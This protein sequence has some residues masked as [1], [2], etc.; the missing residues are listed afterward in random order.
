MYLFRKI[1]NKLN[2]LSKLNDLFNRKERLEFLGVITASFLM[3]VFQAIGV[4]SI[5]PFINMVM[6][7]AVISENQW[8]NYFFNVFGFESERQFI[9]FSGF[10]VLCLLVLGNSISAFA[11][12]LKIHFVWKKNH[13]LS[14][15]LLEK[16]LS[17]PYAFFLNQNTAELGKN[18]LAEVQQLTS[19][20]LMPLT[21][22]ITD[23]IVVV[24]IFA[25][26]VYVNPLMTAAAAVILVLLYF[27]I[28]FYFSRQLKEGGEKR[29][30]QNM[31]R[32]KSANEALGGIKDIKMLG[33]ESYFLRKFFNS[34]EIFSNVQS[35]YQTV[36]QVPRY[37]M[38]IVAFGGIVGLVI[39][40]TGT[41]KPMQEAIPLISFFAFAGYRLMPALQEVFNSLTVIRFNKAVLDKIHNDMTDKSGSL[42][43]EAIEQKNVRSL[44]FQKEIRL[45]NVRFTYPNNNKEALK[46]VSLSIRKNSSAAIIGATGS[47]KTTL[48]DIVL[49]LFLPD[50]GK[51]AVDGIEITKNNVRNWQA[52]LGYVPQFIYL[53]DDTIAR[54]IALG[55]P[56]QNINMDQVK[57]AAEMA[58]IHEFIDEELSEGY[59]TIIGERGI[60]LSGGQRQRIGIAR[61]LYHDP[62]VLI[63]DEATS[64]LDN[65]TEKE[66]LKAIDSVAK[67]KTM[68]VIA[69]RLTTVKNCDKVYLINKGEI[70]KEGTYEE[71][72]NKKDE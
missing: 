15:A 10:V 16:Y 66:V 41:G 58:N 65:E 72:V 70:V 3:A 69:H 48:A 32:Y 18:I 37:I 20:F 8:L 61:A 27:S 34:S 68:V 30:E 71:I 64:S 5:L 22:I 67:L 7:P 40:L 28:F 63:F 9:I 23:T 56:D 39:F 12:W 60:R 59:H 14:V 29:L 57:R 43:K 44:S 24:I 46:N 54:N 55:I 17:M 1:K 51:L 42:E 62:Q 2:F 53:S 4:A 35:W 6:D 26:L 33:V 11:S 36:G 13:R 19:N 21:K 31:E 52:N 38:E 47:G 45:E 25:M 50:K 49:G